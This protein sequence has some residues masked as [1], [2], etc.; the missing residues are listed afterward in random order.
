[1]DSLTEGCVWLTG[2]AE[3][4]QVARNGAGSRQSPPSLA[5]TSHP[6]LPEGSVPALLEPGGSVANDNREEEDAFMLVPHF[7]PALGNTYSSRLLL[8]SLH[9]RTRGPDIK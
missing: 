1:M 3:W 9:T 2:D 4:V 7:H 6:A 5:S 8:S